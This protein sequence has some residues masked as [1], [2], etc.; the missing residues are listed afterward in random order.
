MEEKL[1]QYGVMEGSNLQVTL[2]NGDGFPAVLLYIH[3]QLGE[4]EYQSDN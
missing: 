4:Q 3:L 2:I 1:N